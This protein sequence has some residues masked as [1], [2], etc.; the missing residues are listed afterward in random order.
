MHIIKVD[1][2]TQC[3][4]N[5]PAFHEIWTDIASDA[6][7]VWDV[8][9]E[10]WP[11][12]IHCQSTRIPIESLPLRYCKRRLLNWKDPLIWWWNIC[13]PWEIFVL[14]VSRSFHHNQLLIL[15]MLSHIVSL[16]TSIDNRSVLLVNDDI[17]LE[18]YYLSLLFADQILRLGQIQS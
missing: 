11:S 3:S 4:W 1:M 10:R 2:N 8:R 17:F 6:S 9:L 13:I 15:L 12:R 7:W 18:R 16:L 5:P 14:W